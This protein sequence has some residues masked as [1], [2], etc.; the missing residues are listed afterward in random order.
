MT[1]QRAMLL[2][3]IESPDLA[4]LTLRAG[5]EVVVL[6]YEHGFAS[7]GRVRSMV[8]ACRAAGGRCFVRLAPGDVAR[9]AVLADVGVDGVVLSGVRSLRD[10]EAA[11]QRATFPPAGSRSV[12]PF[13]PAAGR[14]GDEVELRRSAERFEVWAMA[15]TRELVAELSGPGGA[16]PAEDAPSLMRGWRGLILGP[17]DLAAELGCVNSPSDE[18]L[19]SGAVVLSAAAEAWKV[20]FGIFSRDERILADW[21][22]AGIH[23]RWVIVGYDRDIWYRECRRRIE[24][25]RRS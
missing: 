17:Y 7:D 14:P 21:D 5:V 16:G 3:G 13:V 2:M 8:A 9:T 4:Y 18:T 23:P 15:E 11:C 6:D 19:R 25:L 20:E 22:G 12:N 24:A 1:T 10:V